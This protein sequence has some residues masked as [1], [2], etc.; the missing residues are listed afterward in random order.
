[1]EMTNKQLAKSVSHGATAKQY[2][3]NLKWVELNAAVLNVGGTLMTDRAAY[4]RTEAGW[5]QL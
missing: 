5:I 2:K 3:A 1:M 4:T